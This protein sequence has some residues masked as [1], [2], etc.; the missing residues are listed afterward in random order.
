MKR[1]QASGLGSVRS[2]AGAQGPAWSPN[3]TQK[4]G[5]L[6][7][8]SGRRGQNPARGSAPP[9]SLSHLGPP[10][11]GAWWQIRPHGAT[12]GHTRTGGRGC[13]GESIVR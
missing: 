2:R 13:L 11:L 1:G 5:K 9:A 6:G 4:A 7:Q 10:A 3:G 12:R 8:L